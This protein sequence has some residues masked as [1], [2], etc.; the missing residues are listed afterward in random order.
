MLWALSFVP[1]AVIVWIGY[2]FV[3]AWMTEAG[4]FWQRTL[5][6][7]KDS[8]TLVWSKLVI[9][10]GM[11]V[12]ALDKLA[13]AVGDPNLVSQF[14]TYLTPTTV[15]VGMALVMALTVWARLRTL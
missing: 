10:V 4:S 8:A 12:P 11:L 15:G 2:T 7:S 13:T 5:A 9:L 3:H 6:A 1:F 14:Q